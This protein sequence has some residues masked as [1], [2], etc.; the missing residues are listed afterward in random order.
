[1]PAPSSFPA[2]S[3]PLG[4][5]WMIAAGLG[6][7]LMSVCVKA[8]AGAF[9][10][11]ELVFWRSAFGVLFVLAWLA[12]RR[13]P[14]DAPRGMTRLAGP[15]LSEQLR[16][17][18]IG[19][20]ALVAFFYSLAHLPMSVAITLN[21]TSPLFLALLMPW[22]LGERPERGQYLSVGAGFVGVVLMLEPWQADARAQIVPG[23]IGLASGFMAAL[24][25]VQVRRLGRFAE[26]EWR[27]V[28]WFAAVGMAGGAV[29]ASLPGL[30]G[31]HA[32][33]PEHILPLLGIGLSATLA[34]L[35]MTRAYRH[36]PTAQVAAFAYST[37]MFGAL[38]D[39]VIW[40][41]TLS[42]PAWIG[43]V[44]S[45]TAGLK[46]IRPNARETPA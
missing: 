2:R 10:S 28:F 23:L 39:G 18:G 5:L 3:L 46:A 42:I 41:E 31:W 43:I 33:E 36:G 40:K 30:G 27:T 14:A 35:A 32:P 12:L 9:G 15:H 1:M 24:A 29:L 17:A 7:A 37:V 22:L 6:F 44:L 8:T 4:A 20:M 38:L 13:A 21:Y 19:F 34:Q 26:P 25:Y 45:V 16:R 11:P